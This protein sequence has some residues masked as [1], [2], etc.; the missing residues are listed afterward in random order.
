[1]ARPFEVS[2]GAQGRPVRMVMES[3]V[4]DERARD[5]QVDRG[6]ARDHVAG[7]AS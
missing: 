4:D 5:D 2:A 3:R 1:M 7:V 6:P